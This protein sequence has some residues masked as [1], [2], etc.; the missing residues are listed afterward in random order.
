[1]VG[2]S[3]NSAE[4]MAK[5]KHRRIP[6]AVKEGLLQVHGTVPN[7]KQQGI[8]QILE[9]NC[10]SLNNK[11]C[12]NMKIKKAL[13]IKDN[14]DINC[15]MYCKHCLNFK[16]KDNKNDL[17]QMFQRKLTCTA[18]SAHNIHEGEVTGRVQE[19]CTGTICFGKST[20]YI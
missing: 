15:L 17:K 19:G 12:G 4:V 8:F 11:I 16:H 18:V 2:D 3:K 7:M 1:M 5:D 20:G 10:N 6:E 13:D 14:L 9:E